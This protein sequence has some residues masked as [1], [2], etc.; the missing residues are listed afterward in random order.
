M[1][2]FALWSLPMPV[3]G[4]IGDEVSVQSI[5]NS[6]FAG[7][8]VDA[9]VF[10]IFY[11]YGTERYWDPSKPVDTVWEKG[12]NAIGAENYT[13][14]FSGDLGNYKIKIG[15][16]IGSTTQLQ[17]NRSVDNSI[18]VQYSVNTVD[19]TLMLASAGQ[20][21][22]TAAE[23]VSQAELFAKT[24]PHP[25]NLDGCHNI[26]ATVA[27]SAGATLADQSTQ[28]TTDPSQN[29]ENGFWRIAYRGSDPNPLTNWQALV[30][31]GDIVRMGWKDGGFHTATVLDV[32]ADKSQIK[33]YDN[34]AGDD[35]PK[36]GIDT[37][38]TIR[39]HWGNYQSTSNPASVT[40]YRLTTDNYYLQNGTSNSESLFGTI[41][42][43]KSFGFAGNDLLYG[44]KGNDWLLGG[45][46]ADTLDGGVGDDTLDG[47]AGNDK[48]IGGQGNDIY[49]V[50]STGDIVDESVAG[51]GGIDTVQSSVSL[52][53]AGSHFKGDIE[54]VTLTGSGNL[55][56]TGNGLANLL[57]GTVG[58]NLLDGGAGADTMQG[59]AGND[60]YVIDNPGDTVDETG[61]SGT[62]TVRSGTMSINLGDTAHFKGDIE[63]AALL[64]SSN[65][66]AT[67]NTLANVLTGNA[68]ANTL[69]G[70]LGRDTL[71]GGAGAD[72]FQ[73]SSALNAST[74]VDHITD[75]ASGTDHLAF[76]H[77]VFA[78]LGANGVLNSDLFASFATGQSYGKDDRI[79]YNTTT[80]ALSYDADGWGGTAKAIAFAVLDG[81]PTLAAADLLVS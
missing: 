45:D 7:T 67:G 46:G 28:N 34:A 20:R 70:G 13:Q 24:Y 64:G 66:S 54:N 63:R 31:P 1:G 55:H 43:D 35:D 10:S 18:W 4:K 61:G 57:I 51:S 71:T 2:E 15:N 26:A 65:L 39:I 62:D 52:S 76:D 59:G 50:D 80:G 32:S 30:K 60:I 40:V 16:V 21:A 22:P 79:L 47:G 41:F 69:D 12:T 19:P 42:N 11:G 37:S 81:K 14:F 29:I 44:G 3:V 8:P 78:S 17:L 49:I 9:W 72:T 75:F 23:M 27:A 73:F 68:G 48:L 33:V 5:L 74:N 53:L 6:S 56:A 77:S 25:Y 36:D 58:S 38:S